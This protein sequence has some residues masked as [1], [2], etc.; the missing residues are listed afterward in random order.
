[1]IKILKLGHDGMSY[2]QKKYTFPH[3]IEIEEYHTARYGAP[4]EK[5]KPKRKATPEQIEKQNQR[6]KEKKCR[7]KLRAY[8]DVNDY[9]AT[10]TYA[11]DARPPDM[12]RAKSD[13]AKFIR[14]LRSEYKKRGYV[15]RWIRNIEVGTKGAWHIH[16]IVNRIPDA[17]LLIRK[18]WRHGKVTHQLLYEKGEFR[19][20]AAYVTKT[21][22]TDPRLRESDYSSSRNMPLP[23]PKPKRIKWKTWRSI[24]IP[25]GFYL[26]KP[27]LQEGINPVTGYPYRSYTLLRKRE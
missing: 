14:K 6:I 18:A 11:K 22:K 21:P 26:D 24:R 4:G 3:A 8:F 20:L 12:K 2:I 10:L 1:M 16:F 5:R 17:D 7:R 27:S 13:F 15:L 19:E 25:N 9:F 23:E